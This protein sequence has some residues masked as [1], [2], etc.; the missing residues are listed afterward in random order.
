MNEP[1]ETSFVFDIETGGLPPEMLELTMPVFK[2]PAGWKDRDKIA[3]AVE[4]KRLEYIAGAALNALSGQVLCI[5]VYQR[6]LSQL[7]LGEEK[8]ILQQFWELYLLTQQSWI[9]FCVRNFDVPFLVR[10]SYRWGVRVPHIMHGRYLSDRFIDIAER[11]QCGDWQ[12]RISL[13]RLAKFLGVGEKTG[14]GGDFAELLAKDPAAAR[15][16]VENDLKLTKLCAQRMGLLA[17]D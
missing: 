13:D 14:S 5:G 4:E 16:Y 15:A 10:R 8:T 11:W 2:A 12:E 6:G 17:P 1:R 9:G 3:A 7:L